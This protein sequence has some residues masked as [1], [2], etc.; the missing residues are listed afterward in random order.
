MI[1]SAARIRAMNSE[2]IEWAKTQA[3]ATYNLA[4]SGMTPYPLKELPVKIEDLEING[5]SLYGYEPLQSALAK[6]C[7]VETDCVVAAV[8]TTMANFLVMAATIEAADEVLIEEPAYEPLLNVARYLGAEIKRFPRRFAEGFQVDPQE[9]SRA[10]TSRT[11]LIVITNLHNPSNAFIEEQVLK[12]IGD[13]AQ[14]VGARVLVDEVYLDAM[15]ADA[16]RSSFHLG[17]QFVVTSS[18]TKAYG[19]SGLRCGWILAEPDLAKKLWGLLDL[20]I[21]IPAHP[22]EL[23]SCIALANL[24]KIAQRSRGILDTNRAVL[25]RF[26]SEREDLEV[27]KSEY[28]TVI[29]PR[30]KS[31]R[32]DELCRALREKY[33]TTVVPGKYFEMPEHFRLGYACEPKM[34]AEGIERL[35]K[36][37][38]ELGIR[39]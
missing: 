19:L 32:V 37:M 14:G 31:G 1:T 8:G 29:F 13:M 4:N 15:F 2:Y 11:R 7:G 24:E 26:L 27:R 33:E 36:A 25:N 16:P 10:I 34:F 21:G 28:G 30:L 20:V 35:K 18:L 12:T 5:P 38:D 6:K 9:I 23:L 22:A 3:H 39:R 17:N